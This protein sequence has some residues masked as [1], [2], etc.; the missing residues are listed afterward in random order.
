MDRL[1]GVRRFVELEGDKKDPSLIHD[2]VA[3]LLRPGLG[4]E[5]LTRFLTQ[6]N[7]A[8]FLD[9]IASKNVAG[10]EG[11]LY[12]LGVVDPAQHF[13]IRKI[14]ARY[15][16]LRASGMCVVTASDIS[17]GYLLHESGRMWWS[18]LLQKTMGVVRYDMVEVG[19]DFDG[20]VDGLVPKFLD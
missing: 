7:G 14:N 17:G 10:R 11:F 13:D 15:Q 1:A 2:V 16:A 6:V 5:Q 12:L 3:T 18:D 19:T 8:T 9:V 20:F 4:R